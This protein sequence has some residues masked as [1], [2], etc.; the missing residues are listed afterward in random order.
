VTGDKQLS[1]VQQ[2]ARQK[3][4]L[5]AERALGLTAIPVPRR[6]KN[7]QPFAATSK[8][9]LD[10]ARPLVQPA[11]QA[12]VKPVLKPPVKAAVKAVEKPKIFG[13]PAKSPMDSSASAPQPASSLFM[14]SDEP[15]TAAVLS[16]EAKTHTL[17]QLNIEQVKGCVKCRLSQTRTHTVFGEGDV[18]AKLLFIGEGPGENEDLQ[19]RPFVGRAGELLEKMIVAMGLSRQ[20]VFICNIVKCRPP[21]NR[22]PMPDETAACTPYLLEQ[23]EVVRPAVIVTLGLPA[24]QFMLQTKNSMGKMRGQ[25]HSWRGIKL[26]PTYHPAYVLR[27]YTPKTRAAVWDDLK[28]VMNEL[29]LPGGQKK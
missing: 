26:M 22:A 11:D 14:M 21:G 24:T 10:T 8:P 9:A 20:A 4:A 3:L 18:D 28:Q 13:Q 17:D 12:S 1:S 2:A 19:G 27:D 15:F 7:K 23:I 16:R 29:G 25:W 6:A 5:R